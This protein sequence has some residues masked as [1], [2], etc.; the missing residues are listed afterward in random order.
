MHLKPQ[1]FRSWILV[2]QGLRYFPPYVKSIVSQ[3]Y[4]QIF[5]NRKMIAVARAQLAVRVTWKKNPGCRLNIMM[6]SYQF[7][8]SHYHDKTVSRSSYLYDGNL[9]TRKRPYLYWDGALLFFLQ[10]DLQRSEWQTVSTWHPGYSYSTK[11]L[12]WNNV[13][14]LC[15]CLF[16]DEWF[17]PPIW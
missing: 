8:D 6:P 14:S 11:L 3:T 17:Y 7:R 4:L 2:P 1:T 15:M 10:K 9:H 12:I 16:D 13:S 5:S